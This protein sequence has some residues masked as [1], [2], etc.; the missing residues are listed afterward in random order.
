N[1]LLFRLA[2]PS[3]LVL[4]QPF[5]PDRIPGPIPVESFDP[6]AATIGENEEVSLEWVEL[7]FAFN[8][9][10]E[11]IDP[12][13]K[14][15]GITVQVDSGKAGGFHL[16]PPLS[17]WASSAIAARSPRIST[18]PARSIISRRDASILCGGG[19][20]MTATD[21]RFVVFPFG[22]PGLSPSL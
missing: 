2:W 21:T 15:Y 22:R 8:D 12:F 3:K 1:R 13:A 9:S 16:A 5:V 7:H 17:M 10:D 6:V 4:L 19:R 14:V 11:A 20:S 18:V